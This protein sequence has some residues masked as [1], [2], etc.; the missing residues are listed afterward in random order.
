[1]CM[2]VYVSIITCMWN[3]ISIQLCGQI[4]IFKRGAERCL[5]VKESEED[6]LVSFW[7][8]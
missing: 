6:F 3:Y 8:V 7:V 2:D 1:M 4:Y 5:Q